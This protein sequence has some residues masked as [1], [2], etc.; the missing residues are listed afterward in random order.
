MLSFDIYTPEAICR[1]VNGVHVLYCHVVLWIGCLENFICYSYM[2]ITLNTDG[3]GLST[4][5]FGN[6]T[7]TVQLVY[8]VLLVCMVTGSGFGLN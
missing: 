5:S 2:Y 6:K 4:Y 1:S 7:Y 8:Y 3:G